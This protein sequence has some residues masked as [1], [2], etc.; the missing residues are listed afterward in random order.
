IGG[1]L[2]KEKTA[3]KLTSGEYMEIKATDKN[4]QVLFVSS[5]ILAEPIAWGGPIVMNT[6]EE[7]NKAFEDLKNG[8]FLQQ[9]ISY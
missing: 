4:A 3:V 9:K 7:L 8:T 2:V 1:E 6:K 5:T